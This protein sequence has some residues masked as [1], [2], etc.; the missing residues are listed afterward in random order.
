MAFLVSELT[1]IATLDGDERSVMQPL[2][3][4]L[5]APELQQLAEY[6]TSLAPSRREADTDEGP[7][8]EEHASPTMECLKWAC[9]ATRSALGVDPCPARAIDALP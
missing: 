1:P 8:G 2:A 6:Y 3:A 9:F 4:A 5:A 7:L